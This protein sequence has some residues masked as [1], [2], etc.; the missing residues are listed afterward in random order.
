M[1]TVGAAPGPTIAEGAP[2]EGIECRGTSRWKGA[3]GQ[4]QTSVVDSLCVWA[5][6]RKAPL[7]ITTSIENLRVLIRNKPKKGIKVLFELQILKIIIKYNFKP[8][9]L[10]LDRFSPTVLGGS[11]FLFV[12]RKEIQWKDIEWKASIL[13]Q[14]NGHCTIIK[15][16]HKHLSAYFSSTAI[17]LLRFWLSFELK[18]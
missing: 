11:S 8:P 6:G 2:V 10:L 18:I 3:P 15:I 14:I 1:R 7:P 5:T 9:P 17:T 12:R 13:S 4:C 16:F